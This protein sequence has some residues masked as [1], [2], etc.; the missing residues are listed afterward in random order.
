MRSQSL[1][2]LEK[3]PCLWSKQKRSINELMFK[4]CSFWQTTVSKANTYD[5]EQMVKLICNLKC[6][7][8]CLHEQVCETLLHHANI[9][10]DLTWQDVTSMPWQSAVLNSLGRRTSGV[11]FGLYPS[12]LQLFPRGLRGLRKKVILKI[13]AYRL[14]SQQEEHLTNAINISLL[15]A[16]THALRKTLVQWIKHIVTYSEEGVSDQQRWQKLLW[17]GT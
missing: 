15:L 14:I 17:L 2:C 11:I 13:S 10:Q 4:V 7:P 3:C 8:W 1:S 9:R 16:I 12:A 5:D 6:D